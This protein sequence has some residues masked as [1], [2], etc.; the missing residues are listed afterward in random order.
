MAATFSTAKRIITGCGAIEQLGSVA[1][2]LGSRVLLVTGRRAMRQ[3]GITSRA[4]AILERAR[5]EA[6]VFD[7]VPPE[8]TLESVD[9]GRR[10]LGQHNVDVVVGIGGGSVLDV[11]KAIAGLARTQVETA[12]FF[13]GRTLPDDGLP[14]V[15]VPTTSGTGAEVTRNSVLSHPT[16]PLKQSIRGDVLMPAVAIVDP[17]LTVSMPQAVTARSGMDALTQ[18]IESY[19]SIHATPVTEGL[20]LRAIELISGNLPKAYEDGSNLAAREA[21]AY[22]SLTAGMA[23]ANSRLGAVHGMAHPLGARYHIPHGEVC[24]ILLPHVM[25]LNRPATPE[26]YDRISHIVGGDAADVA[27][28]MLK[29]LDLPTDLKHASIPQADFDL[30]VAESLPSGSLKANPKVVTPKDLL[31]ILDA[32][33]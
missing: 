15:A 1:A 30:I 5:C 24:A 20:A 26:K 21:M 32:M 22:G 13:E 18:A 7:E 25:R 19:W 4:I 23:F 16:D 29:M 27:A 17:E 8:P 11:A 6:S 12:A 9:A 31:N 10:A 28:H 33:V 3:A 2:S 14:I